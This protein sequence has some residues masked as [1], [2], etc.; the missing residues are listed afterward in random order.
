MDCADFSILE[1]NGSVRVENIL[2]RLSKAKNCPTLD[3]VVID[4]RMVEWI[5]VRSL[6]LIYQYIFL[7][8]KTRFS[9]LL[10]KNDKVFEYLVAWGFYKG[11]IYLFSIDQNNLE[12]YFVG[13]GLDKIINPSCSRYIG[14]TIVDEKGETNQIIENYLPI[15]IFKNDLPKYNSSLALREADKWKGLAIK[16]LLDRYLFG[17][18][19]CFATRIVFEA[20]MNAIRHPDAD[21]IITASDLIRDSSGKPKELR[22]HWFDNGKSIIDSLIDPIVSGKINSIVG[23]PEFPVKYCLRFIKNRNKSKHSDNPIPIRSDKPI[24]F[25]DERAYILLASLYPGTSSDIEGKNH[26]VHPELGHE[27]NANIPAHEQNIIKKPGMGLHL[28]SN[29]VINIY[30]GKLFIRSSGYKLEIRKS[31]NEKEFEY[32]VDIEKEIDKEISIGNMLS[33]RLPLKE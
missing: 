11:L 27:Y 23:Y 30:K 29:A 13:E 15:V 4:L 12:D 18:S 16:S 32:D 21:Y 9:I 5:D 14:K 10:P 1:L 8:N 25:G 17:P 7:T 24:D 19:S 20:M 6:M 33:I 2:S 31:S 3:K 28:L 22:M 26:L